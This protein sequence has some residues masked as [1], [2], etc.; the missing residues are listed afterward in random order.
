MSALIHLLSWNNVRSSQRTDGMMDEETSTS[1]T[2][3]ARVS[4]LQL[5]KKAIDADSRQALPGV[6][7]GAVLKAG[8]CAISSGFFLAQGV[9]DF[10]DI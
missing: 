9:V 1:A 7:P 5:A 3:A 10:V 2:E 4:S 8:E 6:A